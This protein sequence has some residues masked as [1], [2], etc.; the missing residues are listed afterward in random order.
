MLSSVRGAYAVAERTGACERVIHTAYNHDFSQFIA[1]GETDRRAV[2]ALV[3]V[4][5]RNRPVARHHVRI[6]GQIG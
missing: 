2:E 5:V 3:A 4:F 1:A 6:K